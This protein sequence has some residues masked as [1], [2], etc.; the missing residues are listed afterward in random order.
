[1]VNAYFK[2]KNP[3][4][5]QL[6]NLA[7]SPFIIEGRECLSLEGFYQGI[8]R[9]GEDS[10]NHVFMTFGMQAKGLSK[11]TKFVYFNGE[12][13]RVGSEE[14]HNLIFKAQ[15]CKYS[16]CEKSRNAM[17]KSG[18][19]KITHKVGNDSKFYPAKVY[20][21]HLTKIRNMILNGE[22]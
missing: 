15:V 3:I 2:S 5:R 1:M 19:S 7:Y 10:Q 20:C 8:K 12:K 6:S 9:S 18:S 21:K 22:I 4:E 16:Q 11:N 13:Y 14:H 17:I